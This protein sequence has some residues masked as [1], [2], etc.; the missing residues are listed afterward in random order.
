MPT[1]AAGVVFQTD[2]DLS[3]VTGLARWI[4]PPTPPA[5]GAEEGAPSTASAFE[6]ECVDLE[7]KGDFQ[8]L[9]SR[10]G[11]A[12]KAR[13]GTAE[14]RDVENGYALF[15]QLLVQWELLGDKIE[16][17]GD[18]LSSSTDE[19]PKLRRTLLLSLYSLVQQYSFVQHRYPM[20]LRLLR[21]CMA[22]NQL[23]S[24]F[25]SAE[26]RTVTVERWVKE[27][28]LSNAQ[29]KELWG[30]VVDAYESDSHA[31]YKTT[32]KY[33]ALHQEADLAT[34]PELRKRLVKAA[35]I[36]IR[37]EVYQCAELA[38]S[39]LVQK[40]SSDAQ[41]GP[42][43]K[44]LSVFATGMYADYAK[45]LSDAKAAG[46]MKAHDLKDDE[47][48]RKMR[49]MTLVSLAK[50]AKELSYSSIATALQ[51]DESEVEGWVMQA[52]AAQLLVAKMN[53]VSNEVLVSFCIEREF[54]AKQWTGLKESL[55]D[56]RDSIRGL[57][58]V[59]QTARPA[60]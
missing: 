27:W 25:G 3:F 52:I 46:V 20:L 34:S 39:P 47:C 53:Q 24:I 58:Q 48:R 38:Q 17:L 43:F 60:A 15:L 22:T 9:Y 10:F 28:Q 42:L 18:E 57:L 16:E 12:L 29:T 4:E 13:F 35:A 51:V 1:I 50:N 23:S 49:L 6:T 45:W 26:A 56:W 11:K 32:L 59:V 44:L 8:G 31:T 30:L 33:L 14:E 5:E 2:P 40:L 7:A 41:D 37:S 54:G 55:V 36:T 21:Y 19:R